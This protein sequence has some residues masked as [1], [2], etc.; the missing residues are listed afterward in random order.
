MLG[1]RHVGTRM[2]QPI[3]V[4]TSY[5]RGSQ[6]VFGKMDHNSKM[7]KRQKT[8]RKKDTHNKFFGKLKARCQLERKH[9][10]L[11]RLEGWKL[12]NM[13]TGQQQVFGKVGNKATIR[14]KTSSIWRLEG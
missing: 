14:N 11:G 12:S 7:I 13:E 2:Y 3:V 6:Q 1:K 5:S 4:G 9:Q 8:F 10:H